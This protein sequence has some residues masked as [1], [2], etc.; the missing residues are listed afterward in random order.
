MKRSGGVTASA[1]IVFIGSAF[2]II[3]GAVEILAFSMISTA[4]AEPQ[5]PKSY[6]V[7]AAIFTISLGVWGIFSGT[8][9]LQL[10]GWAR[11]STLVFSVFLLV[12]AVPA[13][14]LL[15]VMPFPTAALSAADPEKMAGGLAAVRFFGVIFYGLLAALGGWW[16]YFFSKAST[17]DQFLGQNTAPGSA[18]FA[19]SKSPSSGR[20]LSITIIGWYMLI[21]AFSMVAFLFVNAPVFFLGF[22]FNGG[23]AAC[24]LLTLGTVQIASGSGLLKLQPWSRTVALY[25]FQFIIFN[26]LTMVL[27]PGTQARY[28]QAMIDMQQ[29]LGA[30][31]SPFH[32]PIWIGLLFAL[33][34]SGIA[35][36]FLV[37]NK[38]AFQGRTPVSQG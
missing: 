8:G 35:L 30:P 12:V 37:A 28:D 23:A 5:L 29:T 16:L 14:V 2:A 32:V 17:K 26:A 25:Y 24:I 3:C 18:R 4:K 19:V 33:P 34:I 6:M 7:F 20:P 22:F 21:S 27:V 31:P 9:L 15:A 1:V 38:N 11:I 36:W 10:R 13:A